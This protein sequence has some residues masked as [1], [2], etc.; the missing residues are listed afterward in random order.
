MIGLD[1]LSEIG[2]FNKP[3]GIHG[4]ISA[5]FDSDAALTAVEDA[6][7][8][9]VQLD[10]LMVPFSANGWRTK[11]NSTILLKLKG[12]A[13]EA[14]A[15]M[16]ANKPIFLERELLSGDSNDE[17]NGFYISEL[18]GFSV[19]TDG[20]TIGTLEDYDDSTANVLFIVRSTEGN[21]LLI[22]ADDDFIE[23]IDTDAKTIDMILPNG[24]LD[25]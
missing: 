10:G 1:R 16:L 20:T 13:D 18:I 21:E 2:C 24:L 23:N 12:I 17:D 5:T 8:I 4:E 7:H 6:G 11:G 25:L 14:Q 22:P 15:A 3:H 19:I 9:F